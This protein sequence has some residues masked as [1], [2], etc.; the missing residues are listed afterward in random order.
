MREDTIDDLARIIG[1]GI[2]VLFGTVFYSIML[3]STRVVVA[4][5]F[6]TSEYGVFSLAL[7]ILQILVLFS[8]FGFQSSL[9]REIPFFY[10]KKE[11][12]SIIS[13]AFVIS[14]LFSIATSIALFI[15][16]DRIAELFG[17]PRLSIIRI[18]SASLPCM[19]ISLCAISVSR[20]F[21]SVREQVYFQYILH[22][23]IFFALTIVFSIR[24]YFEMVFVAHVVSSATLLTVAVIYVFRKYGIRSFGFNPEVAKHLILF[25]APLM[26]S[27][28][29]NYAVGWTDTLMLGYLKS[30]ELVGVYNSAVPLAVLTTLFL[31]S[32]AFLYSPIASRMYSRGNVEEMSAL[33]RSLTKIVFTATFPVL[34]LI[35][36]FPDR[37]IGLIFGSRF[38]E[39]SLPLAILLIGYA[40]HVSLGLNGLSLVVAGKPGLNMLGDT[41]AF[42]LNVALNL[43]LIPYFGITGAA[44]ATSASYVIAN[45]LRSYWLWSSIGIHPFSRNYSLLILI[46][47]AVAATSRMLY[48]WAATLVLLITFLAISVKCLD[49]VEK[50]MLKLPFL[51]PKAR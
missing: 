1:G 5:N 9:P 7:V 13:T 11:L 50:K 17:D 35:L 36:T 42:L 43:I 26:I 47:I 21:G 39:A 49:D 27:G 16:A 6:S 48:N 8:I 18:L 45:A 14:M 20:G 30:S 46:G 2:S 25:S 38:V 10:G 15:L 28:V 12:Y 29:V 34:L 3:F 40:T 51:L 44:V 37:L 41:L 4:R 31:H 32:S 24:Q 23:A 22:P 19:V 33:Y